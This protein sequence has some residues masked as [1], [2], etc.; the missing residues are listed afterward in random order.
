MLIGFT[1]NPRRFFFSPWID[2]SRG[3]LAMTA[4]LDYWVGM[5]IRNI[6]KMLAA[7]LRFHVSPGGLTL[8]W[9]KLER[10]LRDAIRLDVNKKALDSNVFNRRESRFST[11]L[12][13]TD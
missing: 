8:A 10:V 7:F 6:V 9:K 13:S 2:T 4:W 5:S 12:G 1:D 3:S 11:R